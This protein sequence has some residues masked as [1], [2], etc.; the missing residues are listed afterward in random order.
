MLLQEYAHVFTGSYINLQNKTLP[1]ET[2]KIDAEL[3]TIGQERNK[4][5]R[6]LKSLYE[7]LVSAVIS[8]D[9]YHE[10]KENYEAK[11]AV[12]AARADDLRNRKRYLESQVTVYKDLSEAVAGINCNTDLT[13]A[14][15]DRLVDKILVSSDKSI[16]IRWTFTDEVYRSGGLALCSNM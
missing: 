16:E 4:S 10:M 12:M 7:N 11:I 9:E 15:I 1:E 2:A 13:A 8:N 14:L 3:R 5:D 6:F